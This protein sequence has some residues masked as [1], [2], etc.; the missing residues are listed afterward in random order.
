MTFS[1]GSVWLGYGTI[2]GVNG[3]EETQPSSIAGDYGVCVKRRKRRNDGR[4]G[5]SSNIK[6]KNKKRG[7]RHGGEKEE[8]KKNTINYSFLN[9]FLVK[10][11][12]KNQHIK[13]LVIIF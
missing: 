10:I 3:G 9:C 6:T 11:K 1:G 5:R 13:L 2:I 7:R 12:M 4:R 8:E